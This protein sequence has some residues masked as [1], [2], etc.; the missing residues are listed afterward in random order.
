MSTSFPT[1]H[2]SPAGALAQKTTTSALFTSYYTTVYNTHHPTAIPAALAAG[3]DLLFHFSPDVS[4][5]QL[6][7]AG[8]SF[9]TE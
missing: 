2:E 5:P 8:L 6:F 4:G 3:L 7:V 1:K 9:F